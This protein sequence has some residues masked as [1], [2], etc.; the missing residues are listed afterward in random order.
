MITR[1]K[2]F[3]AQHPHIGHGLHHCCHVAYFT[4]VAIANYGKVYGIIAGVLAIV[5]AISIVKGGEP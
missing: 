5:G 1:A 2:A 3:L 4:G